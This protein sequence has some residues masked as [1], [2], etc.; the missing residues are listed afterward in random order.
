MSVSFTRLGRDL[1]DLHERAKADARRAAHELEPAT[2][3]RAVL[4][5]ERNHVGD[6]RER[7]Q[8]EVALRALDA[9]KRRRDLVG[10]ARRAEVWA[11]IARDDR[12]DDGAIG[13]LGAG[14][15]VVGHDDVDAERLR[16]SDLFDRR[17]P[18]VGGDEEAGAALGQ[19]VDRLHAEAVS[20]LDPPRDEPVAVAAQL[21]NRADQDRR[22][23]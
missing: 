13:Q 11:G 1:R 18:A 17:D 4:A 5:G 15:V 14:L 10:D 7:D 8:V 19:A 2:H 16:V 6:G 20:V 23:R 3:Q 9:Q 21:A 12:M 22:W